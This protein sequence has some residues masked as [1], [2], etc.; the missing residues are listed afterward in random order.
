MKFGGS[1][2]NEDCS[3]NLGGKAEG[4]VKVLKFLFCSGEYHLVVFV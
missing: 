1:S 4:I 2:L 3:E